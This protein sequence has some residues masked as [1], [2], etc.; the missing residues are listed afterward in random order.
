MKSSAIFTIKA[1]AIIGVVFHHIGN[2]RFDQNTLEYI[3]IL[4]TL[5]SWS[6]FAFIGISGWLHAVSEEKQPRRL[7]YFINQR[8]VRLMVPYVAL[9]VLYAL[10][11][12][13]IQAMQLSNVAVRQDASFLG[14][15]YHSIPLI[16]YD[17]VAEQLYFLPLLFTISVSVHVFMKFHS[18]LGPAV[19]G[20]ISL[21][22][23]II[24][25]PLSGNTGFSLGM[26][27]FGIFCYACGVL[28]YYWR[29]VRWKYLFV[30]IISIA[31][32]LSLGAGGLPK[33]FPV[34]IMALIPF[35]DRVHIPVLEWIGEASGTIYAYHTPFILQPLILVTAALPSKLHFAGVILSAL[36]AVTICALLYHRLK[37]TPARIVLM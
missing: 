36:L 12:Q 29:S 34:I 16:D 5:F 14:K 23:G 21:G 25:T 32:V 1:L 30:A 28:L 33:A 8:I 13:G 27:L 9:V 35:L 11:W 7:W 26:L 17:P 22:L 18:L 31:L 2:R 10:V 3:G 4:P 15:I 19:I 6:V 37:F 20:F 24:L